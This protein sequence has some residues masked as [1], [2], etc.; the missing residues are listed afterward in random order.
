MGRTDVS[1][2]VVRVTKKNSFDRA[3]RLGDC[4]SISI[5]NCVS[6]V[7]GFEGNINWN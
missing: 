4:C 3:T 2:W 7:V 1:G 6:R 5:N